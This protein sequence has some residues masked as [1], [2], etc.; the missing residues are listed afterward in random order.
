[1]SDMLYMRISATQ[2]IACSR[3]QISAHMH[4]SLREIYRQT[5]RQRKR[6]RET[7]DTDFL[8]LQTK[9]ITMR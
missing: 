3:R 5:D 7:F 1:M 6:E 8:L 9:S 2:N 4:I